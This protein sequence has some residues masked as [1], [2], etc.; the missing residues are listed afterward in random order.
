MFLPIAFLLIFPLIPGRYWL[1][2]RVREPIPE[3]AAWLNTPTFFCFLQDLSP[4]II[5]A[6]AFVFSRDDHL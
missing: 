5:V 1:F 3:K 4:A 6:Y 2:S